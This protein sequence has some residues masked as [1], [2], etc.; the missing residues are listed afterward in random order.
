MK[1]ILFLANLNILQAP[2][3]KKK[4]KKTD[5]EKGAV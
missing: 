4:E 2:S 5:A 3:K 1:T